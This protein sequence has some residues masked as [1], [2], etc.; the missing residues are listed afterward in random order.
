MKIIFDVTVVKLKHGR[1]P[2]AC[3]ISSAVFHTHPFPFFAAAAYIVRDM[4]VSVT[5]PCCCRTINQVGL[6]QVF[7]G[8]GVVG[9]HVQGAAAAF[10]GASEVPGGA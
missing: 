9:A 4:A 3:T 5:Y 2:N 8:E 6:W 7:R 1:K 10:G